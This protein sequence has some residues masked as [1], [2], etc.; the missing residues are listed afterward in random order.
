MK[1]TPLFEELNKKSIQ[2]EKEQLEK[3]LVHIRK[4]LIGKKIKIESMENGLAYGNA[5]IRSVDIEYS[6][7]EPMTRKILKRNVPR[8]IKV[9]WEFIDGEYL[10]GE[11]FNDPEDCP[12]TLT[13]ALDNHLR[14]FFEKYYSLK[15]PIT[16]ILINSNEE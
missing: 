7:L 10:S 5:I 8:N 15:Y 16:S 14:K 11:K 9:T 13:F 3:V 4:Y 6:I 1:L 2:A 12:L